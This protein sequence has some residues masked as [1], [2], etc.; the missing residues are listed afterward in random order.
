MP[1]PNLSEQLKNAKEHY[2]KYI[3]DTSG[4]ASFLI[5]GDAGCGKTHLIHTCPKPI[6]V[7]S[8]D[9]GGAKTLERFV[10]EGGIIVNTDYEGDIPQQGATFDRWFKSLQER[11]RAGYFEGVGTYVIDSF[12]MMSE[13][14]LNK[15]AKGRKPTQ[16]EY[17]LQQI[18][19]RNAIMVALEL[20]CHFLANCHNK[21]DYDKEGNYI[22]D[23]IMATGQ[24]QVKIPQLF[25][26]IYTM[27]VAG[28]AKSPERRL[29]TS[30]NWRFKNR[31]RIGSGKLDGE[32]PADIRAILK[33][34]GYP[35]E[36][37]ETV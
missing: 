34:C 30:A 9:P 21:K 32:E 5:V 6:V 13:Y 24:L 22:G 19:I 26:E 35:Y 7:D 10:E 14:A 15:H 23:V 31:T 36:D 27:E 2:K 25:D 1:A 18:A 28:T 33:K 12:T 16:P 4:K 17:L 3:S 11:T 29:L 37:K 8:F 20:P